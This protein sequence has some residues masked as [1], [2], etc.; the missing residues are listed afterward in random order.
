MR[1]V[2]ILL[3]VLAGAKIL[4]QEWIARSAI[5]EALIAAYRD[6]AAEACRNAAS[7]DIRTAPSAGSL[8]GWATPSETMTSQCEPETDGSS[9][10]K[11]LPSRR[12]SLFTP[13]LS[14]IGC[15]CG[16]RGLTISRAITPVG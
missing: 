7:K 8:A 2:V 14:R 10:V 9:M 12:P 11:S 5:E 4:A 3:A 16:V 1:V 15:A 6:R 13:C